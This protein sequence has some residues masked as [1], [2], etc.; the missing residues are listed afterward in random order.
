MKRMKLQ[1]VVLTFLYSI[2]PVY[3]QHRGGTVATAI[4]STG[5]SPVVWIIIVAVA[6]GVIY[7]FYWLFTKDKKWF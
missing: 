3:A 5:I 2:T 7:L 6:A 1:T 4:V